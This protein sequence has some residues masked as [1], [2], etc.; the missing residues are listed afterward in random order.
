MDR[1]YANLNLGRGC[2][3]DRP[4]V[5][6]GMVAVAL[7]CLGNCCIWGLT[8]GDSGILDFEAN[9]TAPD[10]IVCLLKVARSPLQIP[11]NQAMHPSREVGRFDNG[12]S[13]VAAG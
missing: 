1:S 9:W 3:C 12:T 13:L 8:N 11:T 6:D 4:S 10:C 7:F 5:S 2:S